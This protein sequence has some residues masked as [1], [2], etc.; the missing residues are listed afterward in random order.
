[1]NVNFSGFHLSIFSCSVVSCFLPILT[2]L[3]FL[4]NVSMLLNDTAGQ[5]D[6]KDIRVLCYPN[7]DVFICC[8][9]VAD[10]VTFHNVEAVWLPEVKDKVPKAKILL[11]GTKA[12]LRGTN[13]KSGGSQRNKEVLISHQMGVLTLRKL[14]P[15]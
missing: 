8:F 12:D 13:Q 11:V 3:S 7:T 10:K 5:E 1:M 6:Y 15:R 9:S 14:H 2:S 4:Q